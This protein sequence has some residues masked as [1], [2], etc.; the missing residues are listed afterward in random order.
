MANNCCYFEDA[1]SFYNDGVFANNRGNPS[2]SELSIA[3]GK[4]HP[5]IGV[6]G[7]RTGRNGRDMK[8]QLTSVGGYSAASPASVQNSKGERV[9]IHFKGGKKILKRVK[10]EGAEEKKVTKD[11]SMENPKNMFKYLKQQNKRKDEQWEESQLAMHGFP[12]DDM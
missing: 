4:H 7:T 10:V 12:E 9:E 8:K 5:L 6:I 3:Q 2:S 11:E 1:G